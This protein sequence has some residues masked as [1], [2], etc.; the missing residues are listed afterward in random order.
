MRARQG[1]AWERAKALAKGN[2]GQ[3][4]ALMATFYDNY[5]AALDQAGEPFAADNNRAPGIAIPLRGKNSLRQKLAADVLS[6]TGMTASNEAL[7]TVLN[8]IEGMAGEVGKKRTAV[9]TRRAHDGRI[10]LDLGR[11]DGLVVLCSP[12]SWETSTQGHALFRRSPVAPVLPV[13]VRGA[14]PGAWPGEVFSLVNVRGRDELALYTGCR[15]MSLLPE[16]TRPVEIMTGQPGAIKTGTTK[17]TV[18]WLGGRWR[19]CRR[20]RATG[21]RWRRPSR[22]SAT[23]T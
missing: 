5:W 3:A 13:P 17:I 1:D 23:T 21:R 11:D 20:T 14:V 18:G 12:A 19:R 16:G 7:S 9:R 6:L 4:Q 10:A 2:P 15:L 8:A 22:S